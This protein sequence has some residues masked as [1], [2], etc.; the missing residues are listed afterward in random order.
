MCCLVGRREKKIKKNFCV[1]P[2]HFSPRPTNTS[3]QNAEKTLW[4]AV[5]Q[6][7]PHFFIT[8]A[9][10]PSLSHVLPSWFAKF[11]QFLVDNFFFLNIFPVYVTMDMWIIFFFFLKI[12]SQLTHNQILLSINF[13]LY[14]IIKK[15]NI[16]LYV[17]VL[18]F[19]LF[20]ECKYIYFLY[21]I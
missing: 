12:S 10:P 3:L 18:I 11:A 15:S 7:Y 2:R 9:Y 4:L 13:K 1:G 21:I 19:I 6:I 20:N 5:W 16:Y 8:L 14:I 17:F